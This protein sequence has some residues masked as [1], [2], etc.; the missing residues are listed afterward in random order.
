MDCIA[1]FPTEVSFLPKLHPPQIPFPNIQEFINLEMATISPSL[2]PCPNKSGTSPSCCFLPTKMLYP[3][4][5]SKYPCLIKLPFPYATI[6]D[7]SGYIRLQKLSRA[8]L[9][10]YLDG[11]P[12]RKSRAATQS[13]ATANHLCLSLDLKILWD[14][15]K[16]IATWQ[17][18]SLP[19]FFKLLSCCLTAVP[20][21]PAAC[22][23][24]CLFGTFPINSQCWFSLWLWVSY[25]KRCQS[26][27]SEDSKC[28]FLH[29]FQKGF[30][31]KT[32]GSN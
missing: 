13:Q 28:G 7:G 3:A 9:G 21:S 5:A 1:L 29:I 30:K 15:H 12:R 20:Y 4:C 17:Q 10:W 8:G 2:I 6:L 14:H 23:R 31:Y 11:K 18:F 16:S 32:L 22:C 25:G 19:L 24:L 27:Y 26:V